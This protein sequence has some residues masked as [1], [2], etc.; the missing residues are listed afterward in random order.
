M[1]K[2]LKAK[3]II[4]NDI[5]LKSIT[6]DNINVGCNCCKKN[7]TVKTISE[8]EAHAK[9]CCSKKSSIRLQGIKKN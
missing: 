7:F 9:T 1:S 6:D 4:N 8:V 5:I 3:I 2:S